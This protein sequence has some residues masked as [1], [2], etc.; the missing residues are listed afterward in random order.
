MGNMITSLWGRPFHWEQHATLWKS[1][2][3]ENGEP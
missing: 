2:G 1:L 3:T